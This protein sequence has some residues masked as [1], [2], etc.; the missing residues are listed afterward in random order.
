M[1]SG[2]LGTSR[3]RT[4]IAVDREAVYVLARCARAKPAVAGIWI[5][6][7]VPHTFGAF[8]TRFTMA[9]RP[10]RPCTPHTLLIEEGEG[11]ALVTSLR[12]IAVPHLQ[13]YLGVVVTCT[14]HVQALVRHG[15]LPEDTVTGLGVD[16]ELSVPVRGHGAVP[17]LELR[18]A[19]RVKAELRLLRPPDG[20][21]A[22]A[23]GDQERVLH[24]PALAKFQP[25]AHWEADAL[26][27]QAHAR[28]VQQADAHRLQL[29]AVH[30]RVAPA[31]LV[32]PRQELRGA[33]LLVAGRRLAAEVV[34][35]AAAVGL[36]HLARP[37][38][39]AATARFGARGPFGPLPLDP[40]AVDP[41][42]LEL[43]VRVLV[44][45]RTAVLD[46]QP[47]ADAE[48]VLALRPDAL[49]RVCCQLDGTRAA[50]ADFEVDVHQ[51][52]PGAV[53]ESEVVSSG[54][55]EAQ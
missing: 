32:E 21:L 14:R 47:G 31:A 16:E 49:V 48:A 20:T 26:H 39:V 25:L 8:G 27:S 19:G 37:Q 34:A 30:G 54:R 15:S 9:S 7:A 5:S 44:A 10:L 18:V 38:A 52:R 23:F 45:L 43:E 51:C 36:R 53:P 33:L 40:I 29:A 50:H 11:E 35:G 24:V 6:R 17:K 22:E 1:R 46:A 28:V 2:R 42:Y 12:R 4:I 41:D 3:Y 55:L 13:E